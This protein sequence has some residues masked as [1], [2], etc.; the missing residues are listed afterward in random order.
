M[1]YVFAAPCVGVETGDCL[2]VGPIDCISPGGVAGRHVIDPAGRIDRGV[3][4]AACP[5]EAIFPAD[6]VPEERIG[7][8]RLNALI[9]AAVTGDRVRTTVGSLRIGRRQRWPA[10]GRGTSLARPSTSAA[11]PVKRTRARSVLQ[12]RDGTGHAVSPVGAE[13]GREDRGA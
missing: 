10:Y 4:A 1:A 3:G 8:V 12:G 13:R 9:A 6:E 7:F 5:V 2:E 11:R